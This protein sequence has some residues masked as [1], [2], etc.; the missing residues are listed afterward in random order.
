MGWKDK[1][2]VADVKGLRQWFKGTRFE[3]FLP[4]ICIPFPLWFDLDEPAKA[5]DGQPVAFGP[6]VVRRFEYREAKFGV[7]FDRGRIAQCAAMAANADDAVR[8]RIDGWDR[9]QE[10]RDWAETV[11][12]L[13]APARMAA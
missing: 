9:V 7:I 12:S 6:G 8:S 4:A 11:R 10:V 5:E 3:N 1:S 13:L 2:V